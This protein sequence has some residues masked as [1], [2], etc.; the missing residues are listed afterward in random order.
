MRHPVSAAMTGNKF[1]FP[2]S[3]TAGG[4][5]A[6]IAHFWIAATAVN[7]PSRFA[8]TTSCWRMLSTVVQAAS[9]SCRTALPSSSTRPT[10]CRR[11]PGT[12]SALPSGPRTSRVLSM[13]C[14]GRST[15]WRRT[16]WRIPPAS[17]FGSWNAPTTRTDDFPNT[18]GCWSPRTGR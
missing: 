9:P 5:I 13:T 6:G 18:P 3:A 12:C 2:R 15:C 8:T 16:P 1:A 11:R 14:G 10:S 17:S 7:I 4:R